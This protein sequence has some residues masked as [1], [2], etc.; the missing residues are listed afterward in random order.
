MK[1]SL[2]KAVFALDEVTR[3]NFSRSRVFPKINQKSVKESVL[4]IGHVEVANRTFDE[5]KPC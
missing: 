1:E 3:Q 2:E 5:R 4:K